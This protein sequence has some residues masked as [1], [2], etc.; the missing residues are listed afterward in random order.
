MK[1]SFDLFLL[2][3]SLFISDSFIESF[4][5]DIKFETARS[6]IE[7]NGG[8]ELLLLFSSL[9]LSLLFLLFPILKSFLIIWENPGT[10]IILLLVPS[11]WFSFISKLSFSGSL[12][13][14]LEMNIISSPLSFSSFFSLLFFFSTL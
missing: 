6:L 10:G 5:S 13:T 9:I 1:I 11:L 2:S 4:L 12:F 14:I 8:S 3:S 7:I